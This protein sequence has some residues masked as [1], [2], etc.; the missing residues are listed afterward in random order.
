[1]AIEC[2]NKDDYVE[3]PDRDP[4][5]WKA[6]LAESRR[7]CLL[8]QFWAQTGCTLNEIQDTTMIQLMLLHEITFCDSDMMIILLLE[9][10]NEAHELIY[11]LFLDLVLFTANELKR[12][13][14]VSSLLEMPLTDIRTLCYKIADRFESLFY[15][16]TLDEEEDSDSALSFQW[17]DRFNCMWPIVCILNREFMILHMLDSFSVLEN[18]H[19]ANTV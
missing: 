12:N 8:Q 9:E 15:V 5:Q 3:V 17:S 6:D 18:P 13:V 19:Q 10:R 16:P 1:M 7:S 11:R 14:D 2:D 4:F